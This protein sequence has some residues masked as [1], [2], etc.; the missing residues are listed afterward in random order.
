MKVSPITQK[1]KSS[2]FKINQALVAGNAQTHKGFVDVAS[3]MG[4]G[5]SQSKKLID[6]WDKKPSAPTGKLPELNTEPTDNP[7]P[8]Q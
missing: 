5:F 4:E 8:K 6:D 1:A 2:P 3:S 7:K